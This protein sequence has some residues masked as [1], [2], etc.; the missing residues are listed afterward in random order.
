MHPFICCITQTEVKGQG[1]NVFAIAEQQR[2]V[3][4]S[5]KLDV[6]LGSVW[7]AVEDSALQI[8]SKGGIQQGKGGPGIILD[9][10]AMAEGRETR[11]ES[12]ITWCSPLDPVGFPNGGG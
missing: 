6:C 11:R 2:I 1:I 9:H 12:G 4:P 8:G 3:A 5:L 10:A 7:A